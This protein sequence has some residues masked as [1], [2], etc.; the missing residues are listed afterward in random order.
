M[1]AFRKKPVCNS[2]A[3][4]LVA[5]AI[6]IGAEA[7]AQESS[8]TAWSAGFFADV[9]YAVDGNDPASGRRPDFLFNHTRTDQLELNLGL[10]TLAGSN[11]RVRGSLGLMSGSYVDENLAQEPDWAQPFF[12]ANVGFALDEEGALWLDVGILPS[13]IGF[14]S[15]ISGENPTLTRS[16]AA[17][18]SPYYL[19]GARL[20]WDIDAQWSLATLLV[21]GWQRTE[22]VDGNSIPGIGTQLVYTPS[23]TFSL[24]WSTFIGTDDPDEERRMRYFSNLY[25][26]TALTSRLDLTV[27]LDVGLQQTARNASSYDAWMSPVMI[28]RQELSDGWSTALRVEHYRDVNQVI[29]STPGERG[30]K[31]WGVSW[32]MDWQASS[33]VLCRL[34]ARYLQDRTP[35]FE[36]DDGRL[37]DRNSALTASVSFVF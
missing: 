33:N 13:H 24:N 37:K 10:I 5:G 21:T 34:E 28:L 25:A 17:E 22:P 29:V 20:S 6:C 1:N 23:E 8:E 7:Q 9:Y 2:A 36:A 12:E 31:T 16:L 18:N 3:S 35:I 4:A 30:I 26:Q 19:T 27:G 15:A 32:N 11:D 14:E